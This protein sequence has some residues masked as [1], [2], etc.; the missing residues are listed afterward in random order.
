M[1]TL[2]GPVGHFLQSSRSAGHA[3]I[4]SLLTACDQPA[5]SI[6]MQSLPSRCMLVALGPPQPSATTP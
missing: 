5:A 1:I 3:R 6:G 4:G 2:F